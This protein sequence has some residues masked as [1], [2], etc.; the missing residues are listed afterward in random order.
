MKNLSLFLLYL[1]WVCFY[2]LICFYVSILVMNLVSLLI[3]VL[4]IMSLFTINKWVLSKICVYFCTLS[5]SICLYSCKQ[6]VCPL[7]SQE[8]CIE[9][10]R[11]WQV[12]IDAPKCTGHQINQ[13]LRLNPQPSPVRGL[14]IQSHTL[15]NS[16]INS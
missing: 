11:P 3:H 7:L 6:C 1:L 5:G 9:A 8:L 14:S 13:S 15:H 16:A 4:Y 12:L 10:G 2:Y